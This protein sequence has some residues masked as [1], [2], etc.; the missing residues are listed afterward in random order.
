MS[1]TLTAL[2]LHDVQ[3]LRGFVT[4]LL[5]DQ[6]KKKQAFLTH[7]K[8]EDAQSFLIETILREEGKWDREKHPKFS[9]WVR[10][11][12]SKRTVDW[13]RQELGDNRYKTVRPTFISMGEW[14]DD[15]ATADHAEDCDLSVSL[16]GIFTRLSP[17]GQWALAHVATPYSEGHTFKEIAST[18]GKSNKW[19]R[20]QLALLRGELEELGVGECL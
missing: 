12:V 5:N 19:V 16:E 15:L 10:I 4:I 7:E 18:H 14:E 3:D 17:Q 13:Y 20:E 8:F 6:L 1:N 9:D 2:R 11:V